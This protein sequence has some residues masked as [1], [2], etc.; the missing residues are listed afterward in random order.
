[1]LQCMKAGMDDQSVAQRVLDHI[2]NGT[3]DLGAAVWREPVANYRSPE[4]LQAELERVLRRSPTPFCP[5][6]AVPEAG[7]FVTREA[8][9]IPIVVVRGSDGRVRAFR[10]ACRHRGMQVAS[11][12]GCARAFVCRYHGWTYNLEG[13]LRHIPHEAG[14]PGFDKEAHPLVPVTATE[15]FGLVFVTQDE[16]ALGDDSLGGLDR[17]IAP[18]QRLF[19]S[20]ERDFE[21]NWK[22]FLESFIEGYHIKSTHPESFLPYGFDNLNVIDLFGRNSR[23]TYPFQRIK[24]LAKVPPAE[25]RVDGLLT[26][27]YHLFPNVL[28]TVLS[29]HT[30]VVILEPLAVDRTRQ[31]TYTLTNGGGDDPA[32]LAEARRDA[33]FVG[34]TGALEDRAV[35]HAIQR[36]LA[37]GA[38]EAFTFGRYESA[39]AHFH[40]T[41]TSL[42]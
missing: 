42:L 15:R 14:F 35:V 40:R 23:V 22:I 17:L 25:R 27:V 2:A 3:T 12:T 33:E 36:G 37:S 29:R 6:A 9:G 20:A 21:V 7:S 5:S 26:Y 32:A 39:I 1:M 4:R 41:L 31:F 18:D 19:A 16:P 13:R 11:G 8:A 30:N 24:K 10:N 38:N 28:I 34:N